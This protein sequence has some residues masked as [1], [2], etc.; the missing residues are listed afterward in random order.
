MVTKDKHIDLGTPG[1][2]LHGFPIR[3]NPGCPGLVNKR[4]DLAETPSQAA[5][6]IVCNVPK[7]L[8]KPVSPVIAGGHDEVGQQGSGLSRGREIHTL[9]SPADLNRTQQID[10]Q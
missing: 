7:Q 9:L 1:A 5:F 6:R 8:G 10:T 4:T 2:E 3:K